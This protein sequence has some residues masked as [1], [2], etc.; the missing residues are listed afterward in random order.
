MIIFDIMVDDTIEPIHLEY[1]RQRRCNSTK[2]R[3]NLS[4]SPKQINS[5]KIQDLILDP[6]TVVFRCLYSNGL[7]VLVLLY[8]FF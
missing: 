2:A 6:N 5:T 7:L 8:K 4:I 1:L 3:L